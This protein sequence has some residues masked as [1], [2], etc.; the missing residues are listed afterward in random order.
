MLRV[1][2]V[3]TSGAMPKTS[4]LCNS[5]DPLP[6][7]NLQI[8][9]NPVLQLVDYLEAEYGGVIDQF[10]RRPRISFEVA[11]KHDD[12]G[13][14][15]DTVLDALMWAMD[16]V[17]ADCPTSGDVELTMGDGTG[18]SATRWVRGAGIENLGFTRQEGVTI[19]FK[20]AIVGGTWDKTNLKPK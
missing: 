18:A 2:I 20:Y 13:A 17:M 5:P 19:F 11:R 9:G 12:A 3:E 16:H 8:D 7:F 15:F 10:N 6:R 14:P 4:V 1:R